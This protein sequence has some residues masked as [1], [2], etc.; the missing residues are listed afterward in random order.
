MKLSLGIKQKQWA[1]EYLRVDREEAAQCCH[2]LHVL[3]RK[4]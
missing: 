3:Q 2:K 1:I 4:N